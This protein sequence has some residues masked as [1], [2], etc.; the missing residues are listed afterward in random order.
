[1]K[2]I[3]SFFPVLCILVGI[4]LCS[5]DSDRQTL[6]NN[7]STEVRYQQSGPTINDFEKNVSN[8]LDEL[9]L[10]IT[11][12]DAVFL[13]LENNRA[14]RIE[15]LNPA[16]KKTFEEQERAWFE[17]SI[18]GSVSKKDVSAEEGA[19][20]NEDSAFSGN[21]LSGDTETTS[22]EAKIAETLPT[23]ASLGLGL[24]TDKISKDSDD[25]D[26]QTRTAF[27]VT[28]ALLRGRG[29][30]VN[31]ADLRQARLDTAFSEYELRGFA[32]S[33]V[34]EVERTYWQYAL[35]L[36]QVEIVQQSLDLAKKQLEDTN[37][38][39]RVGQIAE[40]E[41]AASEAEVALRQEALINAKSLVETLQV[42]LFRLIYPQ[43]LQTAERGITPKT[44]P[45]VPPVPLESLQDHIAV[46]LR[47][48]PEIN[49]AQ[50][51]LQRDE[52][53]IVK[54]KNG[55][56]PKM[57]LF[58]N[59]GRTGYANSFS[60]SLKGK[61][62]TDVTIGLEFQYPLTNRDA[63]AQ[64][65]RAKLTYKQK[66][67]SLENLRDL[68]RQ[69]VELAYIEVKRAREQ[70]DATAT[71]RK[72]QEEKLRA[73][74]AKFQV[75]RSTALLVAAA[76]RDLLSSQ[77]SEIAAITNYLNARIN[78]YMLEG[79]LLERRGISAP[80]RQPAN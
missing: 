45:T 25:S 71:T 29:I 10:Y 69:D 72:F 17:P 79:S 32:E 52:L 76:Q 22:A 66:E 74:T 31:L 5:C 3:K 27:S 62:A 68:A 75:G 65:K 38:R 8:S 42:H 60:D 78:L 24:T 39:I 54:T 2:L 23:G 35:A 18:S 58:I 49:Q 53:E 50:I 57:D 51:L 19:V 36:R 43:T 30:A 11:I 55:L 4:L 13:A 16:I 56:L 61:D 40:T 1:M 9:Q 46:A 44:E 77:V 59:L 14:L 80:G 20:E 63:R 26:Y 12:E 34:A 64:H 28:Q 48:R 47:M 7:D 15:K 21:R 33:L 73:E 6:H 37:Q 41:L 70:V 67:E